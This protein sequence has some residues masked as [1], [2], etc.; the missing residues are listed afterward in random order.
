MWFVAAVIV[1]VFHLDSQTGE[2][3]IRNHSESYMGNYLCV[4][5]NPVGKAQCTYT[6]HAYNR[7]F[8][9]TNVFMPVNWEKESENGAYVWTYSL[10]PV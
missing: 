10:E 4:V 5:S 9:T 2:L 3:M 1:F 7:K 8:K 6:L